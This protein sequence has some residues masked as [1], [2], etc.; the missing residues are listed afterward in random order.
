[1]KK[2][3][4]FFA[5][6]CIGMMWNPLYAQPNAEPVPIHFSVTNTGINRFI[7]DQWS[8]TSTNW[9][10]SYSGM[11]YTINL[12][13]P[14]VD[15]SDNTFR[16]TLKMHVYAT[17]YGS[18]LMNEDLTI[19]PEVSISPITVN[20]NGVIEDVRVEYDNLSTVIQN[21]PIPDTR[22]EQVIRQKL[23]DIDWVIYQGEVLS[24]STLRWS[25]S[26]DVG[27]YGLPEVSFSVGEG[28]LILTVSPKVYGNEPEYTFQYSRPQHS[29]F[30]IK[31]NSNNK[32]EIK[33]ILMANT[34]GVT[35]AQKNISVPASYNPTTEQYSATYYAYATQAISTNFSELVYK[36]KLR[37]QNFETVWDMNAGPIYGNFTTWRFFAN[38][39]VSAVWGE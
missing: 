15:L 38:E 1:M 9:T 12:K 13:R 4:K 33:S 3:T 8:S 35:I 26:F 36:V 30:G 24:Q 2:I 37:R 34:A 14:I 21:A 20:P 23:E 31:I 29:R 27:F 6:I 7:A 18:T 25:D 19:S 28:E 39:D 11:N 32:F 17:F 22:I 10:G 16:I 5:I